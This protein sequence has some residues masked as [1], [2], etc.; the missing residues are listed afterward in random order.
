MIA[1]LG[2]ALTACTSS[3]G[4]GSSDFEDTA[5]AAEGIYQVAGY[6][7]NDASCAPGGESR[8]G[9]DTFAAAFS[10]TNFGISTLEIVS[11]ASIADCRDKVAAAK[12]REGYTYDFGF[13]L[14]EVG[15]N[16]ALTGEGVSSGFDNGEVCTEGEV[17]S[18]LLTLTGDA[19][20]LEQAISIAADYP[21]DDHGGC[22]TG[23][24]QQAA[25]GST[26]SAMEVLT[27]TFVAPL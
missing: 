1:M 23:D 27:A 21:I 17:S 24:A 5:A 10:S 22:N 13:T 20:R 7:R 4:T 19:L 15:Q 11:C 25:E 8:L 16:G 26:C 12:A 2:L 14:T 3:S 9:S 6:T 18:T